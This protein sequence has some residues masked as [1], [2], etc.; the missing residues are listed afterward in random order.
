MAST[1]KGTRRIGSII[2]SVLLGIVSL[3]PSTGCVTNAATGRSSLNLISEERE[4]TIG[5]EAEPQFIEEN[6]GLIDSRKLRDYVTDLGMELAAVSE[7][8]N[9]PWSFNVLDSDQINAFA[10]PGGKVFMSRGLLEKMTNEA[11]LAGVLGHEI[12]HVTAQHVNA[13]MSQALI[14]QGIAIG[15]T[16]AGEAADDD[17]LRVLGV[18]AGVGGGVYLL[19][20]GRD[21]ESESDMLG[22]RYMT[23]LGYNPFGQVQVMQIL[24]EA[25]GRGAGP[26]FFATHPLPQTR[27]DRL[28]KLIDDKYPDARPTAS[29]NGTYRFNERAFQ[30]NVLDELAKLAP[31]KAAETGPMLEEYLVA[32]YAECDHGHI[33]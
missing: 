17:T 29:A 5:S 33:H 30:A 12:G 10:L 24:K 20:F 9:L 13:R 22:V 31:A 4:I 2:A 15:A 8:P 3:G 19:K 16:V 7:R 28:E 26:E 27:I 1:P 32:V 23:R 14:I 18:G 11:Q 6:G 25:Q 21:Q